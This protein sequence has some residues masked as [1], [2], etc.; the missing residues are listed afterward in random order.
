MVAKNLIVPALSIAVLLVAGC[1]SVPQQKLDAATNLR[2]KTLAVVPVGMPKI[3]EVRVISSINARFGL[4]GAFAD[5]AKF[6]ALAKDLADLLQKQQLDFHA[7][8]SDGV[9]KV[10][11]GNGLQIIVLDGMKTGSERAKWMTPLPSSQN[12][13]LYL[14]VFFRDFGYIAQ[15][16]ASSYVPSIDIRARIT[17]AAGKQIFYSRIIYNKD[18]DLNGNFKGPKIAPDPQYQ[19]ASMDALEAN[20]QKV[21]EGLRVAMAAVFQELSNELKQTA[22]EATAALSK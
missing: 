18:L 8:I 19:F 6:Q 10:A 1:A 17:D 22:T 16:D 5:A 21:A 9:V 7:D 11:Q 14:D 4:I 13:D 2:A 20:P 12:A 15:S 3:A